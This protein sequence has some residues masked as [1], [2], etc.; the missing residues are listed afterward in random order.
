MFKDAILIRQKTIY[1]RNSGLGL[2]RGKQA[3]TGREETSPCQ[4]STGKISTCI[5]PDLCCQQS[6]TVCA[7]R[8]AWFVLEQGTWG[9]MSVCSMMLMECRG[10]QGSQSH[11]A[12]FQ[13][14]G[15]PVAL[16]AIYRNFVLF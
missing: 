15:A 6:F 14:T 8:A 4:G 2:W 16:G 9:W 7:W 10:C 11:L 3:G 5:I 1:H 12:E 13:L